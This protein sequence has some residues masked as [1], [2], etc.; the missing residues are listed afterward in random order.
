MQ[1]INIGALLAESAEGCLSLL[2]GNLEAV[3]VLWAYEDAFVSVFRC[4]IVNVGTE[5]RTDRYFGVSRGFL[6]VV[7]SRLISR[8]SDVVYLAGAMG[9]AEL[10]ECFLEDYVRSRLAKVQVLHNLARLPAL[11]SALPKSGGW[12]EVVV[13]GY[14][15]YMLDA[16]PG[17]RFSLEELIPIGIDADRPAAR[18]LLGSALESRRLTEESE[19]RLLSLFPDDST[20]KWLAEKDKP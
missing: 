1:V 3:D 19:A 14:G 2:R 8:P 7:Y 13:H 20:L 11:F 16:H 5:K 15:A 6:D 17:R 10:A 9:S 12:Q 18:S 4:A